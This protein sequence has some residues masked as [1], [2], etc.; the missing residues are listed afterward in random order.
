MKLV[1]PISPMNAEVQNE[2]ACTG[3]C[4][5]PCPSDNAVDD[6]VD[7]DAKGTNNGAK[8]KAGGEM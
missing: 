1:D 7:Q 4:N 3:S 6:A 5:C 8:V 2:C